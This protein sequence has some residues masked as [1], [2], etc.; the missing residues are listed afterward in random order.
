MSILRASLS[1]EHKELCTNE[2]SR[3]SEYRGFSQF[4]GFVNR[5]LK[6][7]VQSK[8]EVSDNKEHQQN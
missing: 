4:W 3:M 6:P 5:I 8:R 7:H 1:D 2:N